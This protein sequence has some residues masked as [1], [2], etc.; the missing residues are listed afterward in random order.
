MTRPFISIAFALALIAAKPAWC[1]ARAAYLYSLSDPSV[2]ADYGAA[3]LSWDR[4]NS[5]LYIASPTSVGVFSDSGMMV[6]SFAGDASAG[7]PVGVA[8]LESG[9]MVVLAVAEGSTALWRCNFRG[10]PV[11]RIDLPAGF[12]SFGGNLL[13]AAAGKLYLANSQTLQVL[14]LGL[15]GKKIAFHDLGS[16]LGFDEAKRS[17]NDIRGFSVDRAGNIYFT[18]PTQ[19][20][21][22]V[23]SPQGN[24]RS[25][26]MRGSTPGK[27]SVVSGIA[28]DDEGHIF[29]SDVL[30]AVVMV[31][32]ARFR[33]L[34]EFGYRGNGPENLV[35]P[36]TVVVGNGR[37]YVTQTVGPVKVFGVQFE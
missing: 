8:P 34:G 11:V 19:F 24:V 30:R 29:V 7:A 36:S 23:A 18:I 15:D 22:F 16:Q 13:A 6:H 14:V 12:A 5:E 3:G 10:E 28:A 35:G 25:F 2:R 17:E 37:L 9:E 33:F 31:F 20:L 26:G 32:D 21:A 1:A 27:F 4:V